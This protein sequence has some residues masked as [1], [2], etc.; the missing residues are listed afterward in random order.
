MRQDVAHDSAAVA[1]AE[2]EVKRQQILLQ[3][4]TNRASRSLQL[5]GNHYVSQ[6]SLDDAEAD[7]LAA[8]ASLAV[9]RAHLKEAREQL[10]QTGD[11]NQAVQ[12]AQV[13]LD[14]ARWQLDNTI[15]T[16]S[17]DGR[18]EQL[19]LQPGDS[20]QTGQSD[21][22]VVCNQHFWVSANFKETELANIHPGQPVDITLDM[23]PGVSF[24]GKVE[25]INAASGVAFSLLP[26]QN[27]SG[28]WVKITQRVPV[29]ILVE[30]NDPQHPLLVGTSAEVR[31]N[32][33]TG[34]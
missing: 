8:A 15:V 29:K 11:H 17:C 5:K 10:G 32:T 23:Y 6:Q 31:V 1:S 4:A 13:A 25:S 27:A 18:I 28:N 2:A 16:A 24:H 12:E 21:F 22:V 3:N 33:T 14:K 20:V 26:P 19:T 34:S 30:S 9:A 7:K